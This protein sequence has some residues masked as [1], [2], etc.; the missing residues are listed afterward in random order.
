MRFLLSW[1]VNAT[2]AAEAFIRWQK[3]LLTADTHL[4]MAFRMYAGPTNGSLRL[5]FLGQYLGSLDGFY[6]Q[7]GPQIDALGPTYAG[8]EFANNITEY[9]D[10]QSMLEWL[11]GTPL[12]TAT[13]PNVTDTFYA[14]SLAV[15]ETSLMTY[16][17][18]LALTTHLSTP[19][20]FAW[21]AMADSWGGAGS[22]INAVPLASTSFGSRSN[23]FGWQLYGNS[24]DS[25]P[26]L[27]ADTIPFVQGMWDAIVNAAPSGWDF[28]GYVK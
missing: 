6:S 8:P 16:E 21:F 12:D 27:P 7:L 20:D 13:G 11:G 22:A 19:V 14:K 17:Q 10:W 28:G 26:P 25:K 5:D 9:I 3:Y 15:R 2:V 4:G 18:A 1:K 23:L 24:F